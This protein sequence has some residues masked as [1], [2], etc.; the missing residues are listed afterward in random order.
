MDNL[1][2]RTPTA[3]MERRFQL[4]LANGKEMLH[5]HRKG[6]FSHRLIGAIQGWSPQSYH[7]GVKE[8]IK[9]GFDYLA[10]G[11]L[12]R[13]SDQQIRAILSEVR[14]TVPQAWN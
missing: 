6:P 7:R 9:A 5:L 4:T 13:A 2:S 11:G 10:L 12:A 8:L 14:P 3:E 1:F